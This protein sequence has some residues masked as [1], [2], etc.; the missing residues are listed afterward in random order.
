LQTLHLSG[1]GFSGSLPG[2]LEISPSLTELYLSHNFLTGLIPSSMLVDKEWSN[3]R[4]SF[5]QFKGRLPE[6]MPLYSSSNSSLSLQVNHLSGGIP[7]SLNDAVSID[8]LNGNIFSCGV[9]GQKQLPYHDRDADSYVCGSDF[10]NFAVITLLVI[11]LGLLFLGWSCVKDGKAHNM[12]LACWSVYSSI[13]AEKWYGQQ[14]QSIYVF[15]QSM[16]RLRYLLFLINLVLVLLLMPLHGVL[17]KYFGTYEEQY[18]WTLSISYLAGLAPAVTLLVCFIGLLKTLMILLSALRTQASHPE[19]NATSNAYCC[20]TF[21]ELCVSERTW[22][23]A[24]C[25]SFVYCLLFCIDISVVLTANIFFVIAANSSKISSNQ[26]TFISLALSIFKLIWGDLVVI[27]GFR[28]ILQ[29]SLHLHSE[30]QK[31]KR[32]NS[33]S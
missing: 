15:G 16:K 8:I 32:Q 11:V 12:A 18:A 10:F 23:E 25:S 19:V 7:R 2:N 26:I 22:R 14:V 33:P 4:L 28:S 29:R 1:N 17:T 6:N 21:S 3:L 31:A 20:A 13:D 27:I 5:N 24:T 9:A 30:D